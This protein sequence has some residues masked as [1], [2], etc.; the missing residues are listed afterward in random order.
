MTDEIG[1]YT[2]QQDIFINTYID[3]AFKGANTNL[4]ASLAKTAAGYSDNYSIDKILEVVKDELARRC[5]ARLVL[6]VPQA[7]TEVTGVLT[8]P[9]KD[10]SRRILEAATT[11]LDRAGV[12]KKEIVEM[13]VQ[14]DNGIVIIPPKNK[15]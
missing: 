4:A 8:D 15:G 9:T 6:S 13:N 3:E 2:R 1:K 10:G 11:I 7:I 14:A 12:V 5:Q